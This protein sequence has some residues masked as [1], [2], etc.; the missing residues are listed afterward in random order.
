M[1][2]TD[3]SNTLKINIIAD[4]TQAK[5][6]LSEVGKS[7]KSTEK[8][9]ES[10]GKTAKDSAKQINDFSKDI[11]KVRAGLKS[12]LSA[13]DAKKDLQTI[14]TKLKS[15]ST[16]LKKAYTSIRGT[17]SDMR[18][19]I[20]G[21]SREFDNVGF[22][23]QR[24][25]KKIAELS[26]ALTD[27]STNLQK[28]ISSSGLDKSLNSLAARLNG[29]AS[30]LNTSSAKITSG[31]KRATSSAQQFE[32]SLDSISARAKLVVPSIT[33]LTRDAQ[34]LSLAFQKGFDLK[35]LQSSLGVI[36]ARLT[37]ITS[38]LVNAGGGLQT[39]L[40]GAKNTLGKIQKKAG[41]A[42]QLNF[43]DASL[44]RLRTSIEALKKK[45][46]QPIGLF[47]VKD[48]N[49][50]KIDKLVT[51][52]EREANRR[53]SVINQEINL[54][55]QQR[56]NYLTMNASAS[57]MMKEQR[58]LARLYDSTLKA[59]QKFLGA[60][61]FRSILRGVQ[62]LQQA[63]R[64]KIHISRRGNVYP[65]Y[66][67]GEVVTG[68]Y[69][70][71]ML[72]GA[73]DTIAKYQQKKARVEAWGLTTKEQVSWDAQARSLVRN[74]P[75]ISN[76][77][78]Q[79]MMM[80]ASSSLGHYNEK[81]VGATVGQATKYA[82]LERVM[83]YNK[84]EADD[85]VKNYYG[86]AEARQVTGDIQKVLD[87]FATVFRIT[88]TTAGKISVADIETIM[89][90]MG[91][92]AATISDEGLLRLLAYAEQ[93]K[94]AGKGTSG[95]TGAGISTVGTNVKML[96][97]MAMGKP[98]SIN[99]K[100]ALASLGIMDD[101]VYDSYGTLNLEKK[102]EEGAEDARAFAKAL[103]ERGDFGQ[104]LAPKDKN[105]K[106]V[107][108]IFIGGNVASAG[109]YDKNLAQ[110][111]PVKWVQQITHLIESLVT[112]GK[113]RGIYFGEEGRKSAAS[114]E[115]DEA[116]QK[117]MTADSM[118]AAV[119]TFWAKTGLSQR[120]L[121]ALST[122]SNRNFQLRSAEM[123]QTAKSQVS[124]EELYR[125]QIENGNI[126][127]A[128]EMVSKACTRLTEAFEPLASWLGK[129]AICVSDVINKL[130]DW[131]NDFQ[132][133]A[134]LTAG[135]AVFQSLTGAL[136]LVGM[137]F[138][139]LAAKGRA[140]AVALNVGTGGGKGSGSGNGKGAGGGN[141]GSFPFFTGIGN[142]FN[143]SYNK[144]TLWRDR[145]MGIVGSIGVAL[146][147]AASMFGIGLLAFDLA[148][149]LAGWIVD[150]TSFGQKCKEIWADVVKSINN[151][152]IVLNAR[153]DNPESRTPAQNEEI[154]ALE[155]ELRK[156][157]LEHTQLT[158]GHV[159]GYGEYDFDEEDPRLARAQQL[160]KEIEDYRT[161]IKTLKQQPIESYKASQAAGQ[162]IIDELG[163][164]E[165]SNKLNNMVTTLN[166]VVDLA[167][168][169]KTSGGAT[170]D[171][172]SK[173]IYQEKIG[174]ADVEAKK[175]SDT[176]LKMFE[177]PELLKASSDFSKVV[178]DKNNSV[179]L[180]KTM[181]MDFYNSM[182]A[183]LSKN[184]SKEVRDLLRGLFDSFRKQ[185]D[186]IART[187]VD[188]SGLLNA[189][190]VF[191]NYR[192]DELTASGAYSRSEDL[193][194]NEQRV[195]QEKAEGKRRKELEAKKDKTKAE[196]AELQE[197]RGKKK[198]SRVDAWIMNEQ[199]TIDKY[200]TRLLD[201]EDYESYG[202][203]FARVK[204]QIGQQIL[205]GKFRKG[206]DN[207]FM[208][209]NPAQADAAGFTL[210]D[211][212]WDA[213]HNGVSAT[214]LVNMEVYKERL[215]AFS[216]NFA[217]L[218][219]SASKDVMDAEKATE[220]ARMSMDESAATFKPSDEISAVD[221][222]IARVKNAAAKYGVVGD[223]MVQQVVGKLGQKRAAIAKQQLFEGMASN[224]S[225][226]ESARVS[227]MTSKQQLTYNYNKN[228]KAARA[229]QDSLIGAIQ[230]SDID[231][232]TKN[233]LIAQAEQEYLKAS[234]ARYQ[235]YYH[236]LTQYDDQYINQK[237]ENWQNLGEQMQGMQDTIM[238][239]FVSADEKWLDGDKN[240][241]RD[242]A[243]D[244]LKYWRN[245]AL[246]MG[247][248]K[249][250]GG[251]TEGIT[252]GMTDLLAGLFKQEAPKGND[253]K[254]QTGV[255]YDLAKKFRDWLESGL[256]KNESQPDN[257]TEKTADTEKQAK[258]E[259]QAQVKAQ[260]SAENQATTTSAAQLKKQNTLGG[261]S[262]MTGDASILGAIK[263]SQEQDILSQQAN[264]YAANKTASSLTSVYG[265]GT[266][267][268]TGLV[269]GY[270]NSFGISNGYSSGA[271]L[272]SSNPLAS[273]TLTAGTGASSMMTG[274]MSSP[275][276]GIGGTDNSAESQAST[277]LSQV[278]SSAASASSG[279]GTL[280][281]VG[282]TLAQTFGANNSVVQ[283]LSTAGTML[284][285]VS[286]TYAAT[287]QVLNALGITQQATNTSLDVSM[288]TLGLAVE[289][290]TDVMISAWTQMEAKQASSTFSSL[291]SFSSYA[292]GGI[293]TSEGPLPLK[294]YA[295]GGVA[296][297]AQVA[298]FGE[299]S[300]P[301]AYV[302]LPDGRSIPV[303]VNSENLGANSSS[304]KVGGNNISIVINVTGDSESSSESQ[305]GSTGDTQDLTQSR[306]LAN[307]IKSAVKSE[308]Y[309]QSRPG[310]MLYN[311]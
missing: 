182:E 208:K 102:N 298:V 58:A 214:D 287:Q 92:G 106:R 297:Q 158:V 236:Q 5:K 185:V 227:R 101:E 44:N 145:V 109:A 174:T 218:F 283:G 41:K 247:I 2:S 13:E 163:K 217:S 177:S 229:K 37:T 66:E 39:S 81:N 219:K 107:G 243:N 146:S 88:T 301:E 205:A 296:K 17:S 270:S 93:I 130:T 170:L 235:E 129:V 61:D 198:G 288:G 97:L 189:R 148:S 180:K 286:T 31:L 190:G 50:Q 307:A 278:A 276:T 90:N 305:T 82:Q 212:D 206:A 128:A 99:A 71:Q 193:K 264:A 201:T 275:S 196:R 192:I 35:G 84:S 249:L 241:W 46:S 3:T 302:P 271:S 136:K 70:P 60:R 53:L 228:E 127:L 141:G 8:S 238:D 294:Y 42:I 43:S 199:K 126:T 300:S 245:M 266:N 255:I 74:N 11:E 289:A 140:A 267:P 144:V 142:A 295:D 118:N 55:R 272:M 115:S 79:A 48:A 215:R 254:Q 132:G 248:S 123:M 103:F 131:V 22:S 226:V 242:Y 113:N 94:V 164:G 108:G 134:S 64:G 139:Q 183:E 63:G 34:A 100:K 299:G 49:L 12:G 75:L 167:N 56:I 250:L 76:A 16:E 309:N 230:T 45:Y 157:K 1:A 151:S 73:Y 207:P 4:S 306:Q 122:F 67:G 15:V 105:G 220:E 28:S 234:E 203:T 89:R 68:I 121:T 133:L 33:R 154:T 191:A 224:R 274:G 80:A 21:I 279:F 150:F 256:K 261:G 135:W 258:I 194:T 78:A 104:V 156:K 160:D 293:M 119:T 188:G 204:E 280:A 251:I 257:K 125:R 27:L 166:T 252:G 159:N 124:G 179:E 162:K 178:F 120:V 152:D 147:K 311:R 62:Q 161:R 32:A 52:L 211:I 291:G 30:G 176:L 111:D 202:D 9:F 18:T 29:I 117:R 54:L 216:T 51:R 304:D 281:N 290:L 269:N 262:L 186:T 155:E 26:T 187:E 222:E 25:A 200:K 169:A 244:I 260:T 221:A 7:A 210:D 171:D 10:L 20:R 110:Q 91:P 114:G 246:K 277:S 263:Y 195:A 59:Q 77:E 165:A 23:A 308:I 19:S 172:K 225:A 232:Q 240:A 239:G 259:A 40:I 38:H 303:T 197:L 86:V 213:K 47:T 95:S 253:G 284:N 83:G 112:Q 138:D 292:N 237:I 149:M 96:Q 184:G 57:Q 6:A 223:S 282:A 14:A 181:L 173:V 65:S 98:S 143:N 231:S 87:T 36:S 268:T 209:V 69:G 24:T 85:I 285:T 168:K 72:H 273:S 265:F 233:D 116:F 175:A 310:G 137:G 153:L